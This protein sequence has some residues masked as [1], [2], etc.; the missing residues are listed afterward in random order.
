[1]AQ[2]LQRGREVVR[3]ATR[4]NALTHS[5]SKPS[6]HNKAVPP[7][8]ELES[9]HKTAV[10]AKLEL[11]SPPAS[12]STAHPP[13]GGTRGQASE[14]VSLSLTWAQGGRRTP[15]SMVQADGGDSGSPAVSFPSFRANRHGRS[16][17]VGHS[18]VGGGRAMPAG[19]GSSPSW[20]H[21]PRG[22]GARG[23][24]GDRVRVPSGEVTRRKGSLDVLERLSLSS[25][26]S[27]IGQEE[28]GQG[29]RQGSR[30]GSV[31]SQSSTDSLMEGIRLSYQDQLDRWVATQ[32]FIFSLCSTDG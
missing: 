23:G 14:K 30:K 4:A 12:A 9:P 17:H 28:T 24:G 2:V 8:L 1:M 26:A 19:Q 3:H 22:V 27:S 10:P 21:S 20:H 7:K 32:R 18:H 5:N 29:G 16:S 6:P 25:V 15:P 13:R 31:T 11:E